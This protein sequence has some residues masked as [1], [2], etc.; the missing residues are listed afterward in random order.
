MMG[1]RQLLF[2][3][4]LISFQKE[5]KSLIFYYSFDYFSISIYIYTKSKSV[6]SF[7]TKLSVG[8]PLCPCAFQL[9]HF[10]GL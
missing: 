2:K 10:Y 4:L 7:L 6:S 3:L 8:Q 5:I 9:A 1:K